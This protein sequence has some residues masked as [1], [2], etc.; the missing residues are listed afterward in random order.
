MPNLI[1]LENYEKEIYNNGDAF[2]L[3]PNHD[4]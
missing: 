1:F 3:M 2:M 4:F